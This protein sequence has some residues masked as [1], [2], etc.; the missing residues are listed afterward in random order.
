MFWDLCC[1]VGFRRHPMAPLATRWT[2]RASQP[3]RRRQAT[4]YL[5]PQTAKDT[6][7]SIAR[8]S[9]T[10]GHEGFW[11]IGAFREG[12]ADCEHPIPGE[13]FAF[14]PPTPL[15]P[16]YRHSQCNLT[17]TFV[18]SCMPYN[19]RNNSLLILTM[20]PPK[21]RPITVLRRILY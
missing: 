17:Y 7:R 20:H 19:I 14:D 15:N 1:S 5:Y 6:L 12:L 18:S 3:Q 4:L 21:C 8:Q 9:M 2:T 10:G 16:T 11:G 13:T